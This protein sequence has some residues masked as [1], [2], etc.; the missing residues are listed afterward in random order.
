MEELKI[1]R[2]TL[3]VKISED[4]SVDLRLTVRG[5]MNLEK[6][7][8]DDC[9]SIILDSASNVDKAVAVF[10]EALSWNGNDNIN[11]DGEWLYD[12]LVDNEYKGMDGFGKLMCD[13]AATSGILSDAHAEKVANGV[14][15]TVDAVF[16]DMDNLGKKKDE[17]PAR[18][19][20]D[21]DE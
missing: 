12:V 5:Q 3:P 14:T 8:K 4:C 11:T 17:E 1:N 13:I 19:Q 9:L 18:F 2:A 16:D 20:S 15:K 6:K 21:K 7:F 10:T